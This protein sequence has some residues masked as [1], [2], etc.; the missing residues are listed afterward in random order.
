MPLA[1]ALKARL[2]GDAAKAVDRLLDARF[3]F[4]HMGGSKAQRDVLDIY[5]I[6][7]ALTSGNA[8]LSRRL[9]REYLD[10]RPGSVPMQ[11]RLSELEAA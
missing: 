3:A 1:E 8:A 10:I 6:D 2:A 7:C 5:L 11:D 4:P 9:L